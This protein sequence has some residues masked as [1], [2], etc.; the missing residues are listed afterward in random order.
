L[1]HQK[2]KHPTKKPVKKIFAIQNLLKRKA[3]SREIKHP[4]QNPKH[5]VHAAEVVKK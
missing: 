5:K 2:R 1:T 4:A 3:M